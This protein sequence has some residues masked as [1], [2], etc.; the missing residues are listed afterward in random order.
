MCGD[1]SSS[2]IS[3]QK[4][5]TSE[6]NFTITVESKHACPSY[7][8]SKI[9]KWLRENKLYYGPGIILLGLFLALL[10]NKYRKYTTTLIIGFTLA[11]V[12]FVIAYQ[13]FVPGSS[14]GWSGWVTLVVALMLG[15]AIGMLIVKYIYLAMA[16]IG[17]WLGVAIANLL[18]NSLLYKLNTTPPEVKTTVGKISIALTTNRECGRA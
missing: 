3:T 14:S 6:C 9:I 17:V 1:D 2:A 10:G 12:L 4:S 13:F 11:I 15:V 8:F 16:L 18:Q 5:S 7:Q